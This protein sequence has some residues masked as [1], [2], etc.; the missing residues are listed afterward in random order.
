VEG[1]RKT[2]AVLERVPWWAVGAVVSLAL[3]LLVFASDA[4]VGAGDASL[5]GPLRAEPENLKRASPELIAR[6]RANAFIYYRFVNRAWV[7]RVCDTFAADLADIPV[8]RLHGDAH[9][10]QFA[11]TRDA[12]GLDDFDDTAQGPAVIDIMRYLGSVDLAARERGWQSDREVLF[13]RFFDGYR[14]GLGEPEH[15]PP[16]PAIVRRLREEEPASRTAF[17]TWAEKQM[18]P[19]ADET[20]K[21]VV[22]AMNAFDNVVRQERSE[23]APNFFDVSRVGWLRIGVGSAGDAKILMRV[24]G[25]TADPAD[26]ELLEAKQLGYLGGLA[27]LE[28]PPSPPTLR[29]ILGTRQLGRMKHNIIAAGPD[30]VIPE[31]LVRDQQL[32]HWWIRSWDPTYREIRVTD[33]QSVNELAELAYDAGVQLGGGSLP[34]QRDP[35]RA[36][37]QKRM[38]ESIPGLERRL[39]EETTALVDDLLRGWLEFAR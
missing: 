27:C 30:L 17:L 3:A 9:V 31:L 1:R 26:D 12:W 10:E 15:L 25:V 37:M 4:F 32:R 39:R 19:M 29:I 11:F 14:D 20:V 23:L 16:M 18:Q 8:V 34:E 6:L 21:A 33:L 13:N 5:R 28:D 22:V 38:L 36:P 24:Q 35:Q 7:T 2:L